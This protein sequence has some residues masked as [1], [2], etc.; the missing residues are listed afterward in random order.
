MEKS[1]I[2]KETGRLKY[3]ISRAN[4]SMIVES[5]AHLLGSFEEIPAWDDVQPLQHEYRPIDV[6]S[7]TER[8][9]LERLLGRSLKKSQDPRRFKAHER[10]PVLFSKQ[11]Q[12]QFG[13]FEVSRILKFDITVCPKGSITVGFDLSHEF[14]HRKNLYW[15][16]K[17]QSSLLQPGCKVKDVIKQNTY[18][19]KQV[20][21]KP[22]S[23]P[24]LENGQNLIEYYQNQGLGRFVEGIPPETLAVSCAN[25][26][27]KELPFIPQL[28]KLVC[29]WETVPT[30]AKR[31]AKLTPNQRMETLISVMSEVLEMWKRKTE[32]FSVRYDKRGLLAVQ[33]GY[34][35]VALKRP[36]LEFGK[37]V[38][39]SSVSQSLLKGGVFTPTSRPVEVQFL[40]DHEIATQFTQRN[41]DGEFY[42]PLFERLA[43]LSRKLGVFLIRPDWESGRIARIRF[44][45]P[46]QLRMD[47]RKKAENMQPEHPI[48]LW[49]KS[50]I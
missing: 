4:G 29:T 17:D 7:F 41:A 37:G 2:E 40:V 38:K 16:L 21:D 49:R 22:V 19:F 36:V 5:S 47:L 39:G 42:F 35:V 15:L 13:D 34:Q 20:L 14:T 24:H 27:G 28:M 25:N 33:N 6:T 32:Y 18:V 48:S 9:L 11:D 1:L 31:K 3:A 46:L 30:D 26:E 50:P 23:H 45:H 43:E 12:D 10:R 44:D 8:R